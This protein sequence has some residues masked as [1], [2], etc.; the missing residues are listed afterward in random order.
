[1]KKTVSY[2]LSAALLVVLL[3]ACTKNDT[4]PVKPNTLTANSTPGGGVTILTVTPG[5]I[6][7]FTV[8]GHWADPS[9][10]AAGF[11][12]IPYNLANNDSTTTPAQVN[13]TGFFNSYFLRHKVF[14]QT[15]LGY[16]DNTSDTSLNNLTL[17]YVTANYHTAFG[18]DSIG[19][20]AAY[21]S[22]KGYYTYDPVTHL[23]VPVTSRFVIVANNATIGSATVVYAVKVDALPASSSGTLSKANIIGRY[24]QF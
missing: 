6:N 21:N 18:T 4:Q 3:Q 22:F 9:L 15:F 7:P 11:G 10:G 24:K 8:L 5:T 13:F 23:P 20:S 1:M 17:T 14:P 2:L 16:V 12:S 19:E